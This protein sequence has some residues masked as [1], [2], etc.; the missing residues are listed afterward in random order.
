MTYEE[1]AVSTQYKKIVQIVSALSTVD[2]RIVEE[3]RARFCGPKGGKPRERIIKIGGEVPIGFKMDVEQFAEAIETVMWNA[4]GRVNPR[5][6]KEA[7]AFAR[8][9]GL[10]S[11]KDWYAYCTPG[12]KPADMPYSPDEVYH[13]KGWISWG[14]W[15]G[16]GRMSNIGRIYRPFEEARAYARSLG[17]ESYQEWKART[18]HLPPGIPKDPLKVYR[19]EWVSAADFLGSDYRKGGYRP[20]SEAREFA[21]SLGL[22]TFAQWRKWAKSDARPP[23]N[24]WLLTPSIAR[25]G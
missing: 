1:F 5:P 8:S 17:L 15:L 19:E 23:A 20:F 4:I 11:A 7:R 3:L 21:R 18:D 22:K 9:L 25:S 10:K 12:Q 16:T 14:D 24:R 6:F 13:N 2:D